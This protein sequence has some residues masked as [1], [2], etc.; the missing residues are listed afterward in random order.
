MLR[1]GKEVGTEPQPSKSAPKEDEKL[2]IGEENQAKA[3]AR[4]ET[5]LPQPPKH[6]NSATIGKEGPI[7]VNSNVIPLNVPFP[8]RFLQAKNEE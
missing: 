8:S 7:Q 3:T 1:S 4:V 6:S 2:Q 5:P